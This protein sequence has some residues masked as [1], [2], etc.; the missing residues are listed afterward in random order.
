MK[1]MIGGTGLVA[2]GMSL[3][4]SACASAPGEA[5]GES[6]S[7]IATQRGFGKT[8]PSGVTAVKN[9]DLDIQ[10]GEFVSL[11]GPSGCGTRE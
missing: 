1:R 3:T 4:I 5:N 8:F 11:R 9:L 2:I 6:E 7:A 10:E